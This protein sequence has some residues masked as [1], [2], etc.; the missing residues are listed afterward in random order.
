MVRAFRKADEIRQQ[1][2]DENAWLNGLYAQQAIASTIGN[3]FQKKGAKEIQYPNEPYSVRA[4]REKTEAY[5][6]KVAEN[7]R[8]R[9]VALLDRVIASSKKQ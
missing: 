6:R 8:V 9:L 2:I 1:R 5:R 4:K 3:A 7:E